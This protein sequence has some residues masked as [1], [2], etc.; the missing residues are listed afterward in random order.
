MHEAACMIQFCYMRNLEMQMDMQMS[1]CS[2]D[3]LLQV[4]CMAVHMLSYMGDLDM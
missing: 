3:A 4:S 1:I 2:L